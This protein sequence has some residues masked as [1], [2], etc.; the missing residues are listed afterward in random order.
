MAFNDANNPIFL[1]GESQ[2]LS[3][4]IYLYTVISLSGNISQ[5]QEI[6]PESAAYFLMTRN[7]L[8]SRCSNFTV[9]GQKQLFGKHM[10]LM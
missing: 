7:Q 3:C 2:S 5:E 4:Y 10:E 1:E 6:Y 8:R 9:V